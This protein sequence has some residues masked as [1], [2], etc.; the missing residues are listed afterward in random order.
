MT[1]SQRLDE[2]QSGVGDRTEIAVWLAAS[3]TDAELFEL[4]L[5]PVLAD[6]ALGASLAGVGDCR[7]ELRLGRSGCTVVVRSDGPGPQSLVTLSDR[8]V[9]LVADDEGLRS[10]WGPA[11][12]FR[13]SDLLEALQFA[14]DEADGLLYRPSSERLRAMRRHAQRWMINEDLLLSLSVNRGALQ[15][16]AGTKA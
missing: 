10:L 8:R 5:S 6:R 4:M 16:L 3:L 2:I 12:T 13:T 9:S 15:T 7:A 11:L 1:I 14:R